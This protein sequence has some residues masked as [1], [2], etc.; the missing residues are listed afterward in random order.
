MFRL[1][2]QIETD[3]WCN[4]LYNNVLNVMLVSLLESVT[5]SGMM[6]C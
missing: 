1:V 6:P 4:I 2:L 3:G 5:S